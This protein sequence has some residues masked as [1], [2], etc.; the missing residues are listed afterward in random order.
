MTIREFAKLCNVSPA[1]VSRYYNG[2]VGLSPVVAKNIEK[3]AAEVG[4]KPVT[5][6]HKSKAASRTFV[7]FVPIW[8]HC[9][10]NDLLFYLEQTARKMNLQMMVLPSLDQDL[11]ACVSLLKAVSPIGVLL[12]DELV[13]DPLAE[14]LYRERIP[15]VMCGSLSLNRLFPAVHIDDMAAAY[16]GANYLIGLGHK[17]IG[18]IS[19]KPQTISSGFQR[20]MGCRKALEDSSLSLPDENIV[21]GGSSFQDGYLGMNELFDRKISI[22]AV[23]TFSDDMAAGA[24]ISIIEHGLSVPDDISVLAFDNCTVAKET[25]PRLT[26]LSQPIESIAS[27]SLELLCDYPEAPESITLHHTLTERESCARHR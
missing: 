27:R 19:A 15:A 14:L 22:T 26:T 18:I 6:A 24:I 17:N 20:I 12:L 9:F 7:V 10:F 5:R 21:Y 3:V 23:F 16:D 1:T 2:G 13:D 25:R 11:N 4:Y 8:R